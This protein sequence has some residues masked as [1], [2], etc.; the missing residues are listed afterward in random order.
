MKKVYYFETVG[1]QMNKLDSELVVN[2]LDQLG[3]SRADNP[4]SASVIIFNT[5]SVR[6]HAEDKILTKI[7]QLRQRHN[8]H[9]DFV[10][11]VIGCMA[12]RLG[13]DILDQYPQVSI[14]CAP[15]QLNSL[16]PMILQSLQ[17]KDKNTKQTQKLISLNNPDQVDDL[18]QLES[19]RS[20]IDSPKPFMAFL[21]IMRGCNKF[22]SYCVVPHVRGREHSRPLANIVTEAHK[23][24]DAGVKEITLLGQTVNS[25]KHQANGQAHT[26]ADVLHGLHEINDLLR[27]RFV[28]SHPG[29]FNEN[30]LRAMADL[31]KVCPYLHIPAQSGSDRILKAMNRHY[32]TSQYLELIEKARSIV[33]DITFAG[34]FITGYCD[35]TDQDQQDTLNLIKKVRY[36]NCF[37]FKYSPRTDTRSHKHFKD[38]VPPEVKQ[39]RLQEVLDLQNQ[40]SLTDN[41]RFINQ[42]IQ[43]LVEGPS[44][45]P[46]LDKNSST[47]VDS[48]IQLVGRT[49]G[50]HIVVF[51]SPKK[52]I[53]K[54]VNVKITKVSPL[55]LFGE[56]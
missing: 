21:R 12:Q 37:V 55:T 10:L 7:S 51:N 27:I 3:F 16:V 9:K 20:F 38:N 41:Q 13:Q 17:A 53:G 28:T 25:Y 33:P 50:D 26:L 43:V 24:V 40:I 23:L 54:L 34:D 35:E 56:L 52:H 42:T 29:N 22:C 49:P 4:D 14:V 36:K 30:I 45:K 46:H 15:G 6:Q 44:K 1:C 48:E 2:Q 18:E 5:C 31:P 8:Q 39:K 47:A 11:A 32:T 19:S